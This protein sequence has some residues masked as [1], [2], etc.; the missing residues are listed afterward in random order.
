MSEELVEKVKGALSSV[1][2]PHMGISILEM[3]LIESVEVVENGETV[4]KIVIKPTNP[5]CMS[6][7]G[8][9]MNAR[10]AAEKLDE[11]DKAEVTVEGHMMA[12]AINE[13][14]NK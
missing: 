9:A 8:M 14:V 2:D 10:V 6:A 11:I 1:P 4:A 5:G 3:G 7:A 13:M 12:E